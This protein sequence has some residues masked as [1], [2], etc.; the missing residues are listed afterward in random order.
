MSVMP[1]TASL[2]GIFPEDQR[3]NRSILPAK[4]RLSST[5]ASTVRLTR[6]GF[7]VRRGVTFA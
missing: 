7:A 1:A 3:N 6:G 5:I 2:K 4:G